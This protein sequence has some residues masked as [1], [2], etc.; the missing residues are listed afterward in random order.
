[1]KKNVTI[2]FHEIRKKRKLLLKMKLTLVVLL[3][4]FMQ[5]SATVYSQSTKFTF[6]VKQKQ[7]VD[8][9][10]EI[11]DNSEF[12]FFYQREQVDVERKINLNVEDKTVEEILSTMFKDEG[13][14]YKVL[15]NKLSRHIDRYLGGLK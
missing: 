13:V 11:E 15:E 14:S 8:V 2:F 7:V 9:L 4:C 5:V 1:M 12:R 6:D 3:A 10:R